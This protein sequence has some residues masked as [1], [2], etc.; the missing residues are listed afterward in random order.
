MRGCLA[1]QT[2]VVLTEELRC[3]MKTPFFFHP[4][5][6]L[7]SQGS[8]WLS[9]QKSKSQQPGWTQCGLLP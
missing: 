2:H 3:R 1:H 9:F 7:E 8:R 5:F 4:E 6:V